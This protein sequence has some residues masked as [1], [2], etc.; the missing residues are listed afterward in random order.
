MAGYPGVPQRREYVAAE[1]A[2][3]IDDEE[4]RTMVED[5]LRSLRVI[6]QNVRRLAEAVD[7][8]D[9]GRD[10]VRVVGEIVGGEGDI[11]VEVTP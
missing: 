6:A 11:P 9:S 7:V 10:A 3:A 2:A 1:W 4:I 5:A 8:D